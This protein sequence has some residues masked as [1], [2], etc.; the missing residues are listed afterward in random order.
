MQDARVGGRRDHP[1]AAAW[2]QHGQSMATAWQHGSV[3]TA[4]QHGSMAHGNGMAA[5][6]KR[7]MPRHSAIPYQSSNPCHAVAVP[8]CRCHAAM[9][10]PCRCHDVA[11]PLPCRRHAAAM[12]FPC[13]PHAVAMPMPCRCHAVGVPSRPS[14]HLHAV[15]VPGGTGGSPRKPGS[16]KPFFCH[17]YLVGPRSPPRSISESASVKAELSGRG[18]RWGRGWRRGTAEEMHDQETGLDER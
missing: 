3:A 12:P 9:P 7:S 17:L 13:R 10:S 6:W 15:A 1:M 14:R 5:A 2:H 18:G 11:M 8:P 4:P 16:R